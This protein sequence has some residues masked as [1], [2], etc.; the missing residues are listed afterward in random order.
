VDK[1]QNAECIRLFL[2]LLSIPDYTA[3]CRKLPHLDTCPRFSAAVL[4]KSNILMVCQRAVASCAVITYVLAVVNLS[5][6]YWAE[7]VQESA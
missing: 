1:W 2:K 7:F 5:N 6:L 3:K 4:C